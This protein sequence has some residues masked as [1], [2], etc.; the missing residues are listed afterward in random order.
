MTHVEHVTVLLNVAQPAYGHL[1]L[2]FVSRRIH[3]LNSIHH[4][5]MVGLAISSAIVLLQLVVIGLHV[6]YCKGLAIGEDGL[7]YALQKLYILVL[8]LL[9]RREDVHVGDL[10]AFLRVFVFG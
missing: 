1:I 4:F 10:D 9:L 2:G 5:H 6:R 3:S 7:L 8:V